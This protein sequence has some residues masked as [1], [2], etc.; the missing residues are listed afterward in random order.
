LPV[1]E[2]I[3]VRRI[4]ENVVALYKA[5]FGGDRCIEIKFGKVKCK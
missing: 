4:Q 5:V 1:A 3:V 2:E